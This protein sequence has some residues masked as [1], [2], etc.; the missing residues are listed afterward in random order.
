MTIRRAVA[1][2]GLFTGGFAIAATPLHPK[3]GFPVYTNQPPG[4]QLSGEHTPAATPPLTPEEARGKFVLPPGFE[5]RLFASEPEV[6][7]PVAMTWDERG[8]L[9]VLELYEYPLGAKPGEPGRDRIKILEDTDNDGRADKVTVFLDGLNLAT[10]LLLGNGG[11]YVGAA[12]NLYWVEDTDGDGKADRKTI[13]QTGFGLEDRHELLNGFAWGPDGQMY[14]THGVFTLSRTTDPEK[15]GRPTVLTAGVARFQPKTRRLEV[16]S[17]GTSNPWG[18]DFD[19]HGNAFVSAC[20]IDHFFH[21]APGGLYD[22]QAGQPPFPYA[23]GLLPSIVD[24]HH[25]MAAYAGVCI[26]QGDQ[27]P[28][29][30][31]GMALEGN[32]HANAIH[33]DG[34]APKGSTFTASFVRDFVQANDGWFMP[35]STQ[36][37]PDGAVWIM[38]WHDRYPCY[39]NAGADPGGVDRERGRIW[40]VVY[41]GD[42]PGKPVPSH[43]AGLDLAHASTRD[44]VGTLAHPNVWHR[45][46][47]QRV[48]GGRGDVASQRPALLAMLAHGATEDARLAAL[49]TLF[50]TGLAD[51]EILDEASDSDFP[52]VR[53][54]SARFTGEQGILT[55]PVVRRLKRLAA[56]ESPVVHSAVATALRQFTSGSLTLDTPP[57]L[58]PA[59]TGP[60]IQEILGVLLENTRASGD[61][62]LPFLLWMAIEPT[63]L[64]DPALTKEWF[65]RNGSRYLPLSGQLVHKTVRR[66]LDEGK[67]GLLDTALE[68]LEALP[69]DSGLLVPLLDGLLEGQ[70]GRALVPGKS[71]DALLARLLAN[72]SAAVVTRAQQ[73]GTAWGDANALKASIARISDAGAADTDRL[74][75]Y[76]CAL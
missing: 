12:P 60:S 48:L 29:E 36:S 41:T 54:W 33:R 21:L 23:Y 68:L 59:A 44:L 45:R 58:D 8:R 22:R 47:A 5:I 1:L 73:L 72:P 46:M 51:A 57:R 4:K 62:D 24:H 75:D 55:E 27:F 74:A 7:N 30:F 32:I 14:M 19:A 15:P 25:H 3:F 13:V 66:F 67:P 38:D 43:P 40:R 76:P 26:Y 61:R 28:A 17:E 9:W 2:V 69:A 34:L 50:S 20:V 52:A 11:A 70:R 18:V 37:G 63:L 31:K 65:L 10:G 53:Q 56:D 42:R 6:V 35:V 39:Q 49:W 64:Y 71:P 16:F